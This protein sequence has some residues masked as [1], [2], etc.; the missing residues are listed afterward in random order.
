MDIVT[1]HSARM[2]GWLM[3][4]GVMYIQTTRKLDDPNKIVFK[5]VNTPRL[6]QLME[7]ISKI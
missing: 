7:A 4:N 2:A 3:F 6:Q 1:V 5:F